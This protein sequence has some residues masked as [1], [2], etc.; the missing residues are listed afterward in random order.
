MDINTLTILIGVG[1]ITGLLT[2]VTSLV[3]LLVKAR[4]ENKKTNAEGD[5]A[6]GDVVTKF[7]SAAGATA[8]QNRDLTM[9]I[10]EL[11]KRVDDQD[12]KIDC[13][14]KENRELRAWAK[15]LVLQ[16]K[17]ANIIPAPFQ[18]VIEDLK[19]L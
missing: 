16:L 12:I 3:I 13:L 7:A 8:T 9:R 17:A 1:G 6:I 19:E 14:E 5:S 15:K 2:G 18:D 4:S 10:N 11:V